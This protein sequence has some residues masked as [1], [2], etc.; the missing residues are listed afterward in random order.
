[1]ESANTCGGGCLSHVDV[2]CP[3][4]GQATIFA[5][6]FF[7]QSGESW[8]GLDLTWEKNVPVHLDFSVG[9]SSRVAQ[10]LNGVAF[11]LI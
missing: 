11:C 10:H 3:V 4:V 6:D 8:F 9:H 1:M 2:H 7:F 5:F